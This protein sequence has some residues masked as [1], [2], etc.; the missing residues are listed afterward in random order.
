[1]LEPN[2]LL[3]M[4]IVVISSFLIPQL[5]LNRDMLPS[6]ILRLVVLA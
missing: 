1:M 4:L 5:L 6:F 2:F 3:S